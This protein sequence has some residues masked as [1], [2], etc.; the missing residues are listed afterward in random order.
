MVQVT[1]RER[2]DAFWS[3][4]LGV[5]AA[6]FHAPGIH[7]FINP[8]QRATW[9]GI[10]VLAFDKCACVFS[11][12]DLIETVSAAIT[13]ASGAG[14][15]DTS[16][17]DAIVEPKT[18]HAMADLTIHS[19]LGP[20]LHHYRDE[21]EG[22]RE[23]A[24]GR[25]INPS[26]AEAIAELHKA[27]PDQEWTAAGFTAGPTV[28]FGIF[29]GDSMMAGANLTYGP[30]AATDIGIVVHPEA[31][32][33]GYG[34]QIAAAAAHQAIKM[35]GIARFRVLATSSSTLAIASKLGFE[36]YGRNLTV[37]LP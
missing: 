16:E 7:V 15:R 18:W 36:S 35:R 1:S 11:P 20:V 13:S 5:D 30:D 19:A 3:S 23:L 6:Q 4:T 28:L 33:K 8:P 24:A 14:Q 21:P 34:V 32:G 9:R 31:H 29:E 17:I 37:S 12:P 10:Y 26:D 27:V 2:V 22:L 25:R